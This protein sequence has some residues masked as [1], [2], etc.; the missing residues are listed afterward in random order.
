MFE[1]N[2]FNI[3][4]SR[5]SDNNFESVLLSGVRGCG[6]T[7]LA[8]MFS[9]R[10]AQSMT[11]S[12]SESHDRQAFKD[13]R[14]GHLRFSDLYLLRNRDPNGGRT[15]LFLDDVH[16]AP[17]IWTALNRLP[18]RPANL[19]LLGASDERHLPDPQ[20]VA[21]HPASF[22]EFLAATGETEALSQYLEVPC[23]DHAHARLLGLFH[24]F[25]LVGGMP[26]AVSAWA[27][28]RNTS[29]VEK[30]FGHILSGWNRLIVEEV[31]GRK[32]A[33]LA[34][35][36]LTD[37]FPFAAERIRFRGFANR[38]VRSRE[39]AQAFRTLEKLQFVS[40]IHP[41]TETVPGSLPDTGRSPRLQFADTGMVVFLSGIR[42][43]YPN[44]PT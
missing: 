8:G 18:N 13:L 24:R 7:T 31:A 38:P 12:L 29:G 33:R 25:V 5:I 4:N 21:L 27:E 11:F 17:E 2:A 35:E 41:V 9:K 23:P 36:L 6:K 1:R 30:A 43:P 19:F 28:E 34:S 16:A 42:H 44:R 37:A 22:P 14:T 20:T 32:S 10:F 15:L 40:L 3:L 26:E 39:A